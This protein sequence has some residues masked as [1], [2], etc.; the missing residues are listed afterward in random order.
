MGEISKGS[1]I[2]SIRGGD[3]ELGANG[4]SA[5]ASSDIVVED[6]TPLALMPLEDSL[7]L[8]L[9]TGSATITRSTIGTF[10]DKDDGLVKTA[11]IDTARFEA[12]SVLIEGASTNLLLRSEEFDNA[13][14]IKT[15]ASISANT[16]TA[17]DGNNTAD[18]IV[19]NTANAEHFSE[20]LFST[21]SG[22]PYTFSAYIKKSDHNTAVL[23]IPGIGFTGSAHVTLDFT[24]GVL[25]ESGTI[26]NSRVQALTGG[27]FRVSITRTAS[28]TVANA[29]ARIHTLQA[30][31]YT[32]DG[33]SGVF[34][35]RGQVEPL[36][37]ASSGIST[38]TI[39]VTKALED[40]DISSSNIPAPTDDYTVSVEVDVS[41]LDSTKTQTVYSVDGETDR[42]IVINTTTG[43]VE[44]THGAVTSVSTTALVPGTKVKLAFVVDGTNQT[45]YIN[46]VQEDQDAKGTVT[47]AAT[48][49]SIGNAA[50]LNELFGHIKSF[51]VYDVA[52]TA[53]QVAAL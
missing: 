22:N 43:L 50:G 7:E 5:V 1:G 11:A 36:P 26:D 8:V 35:W 24:I 47:G 28:S 31:S 32:G 23:R 52:L 44:A 30:S 51:R 29:L 39:S 20:Q 33:T 34:V 38:T 2:S 42:K 16:T 48:A 19:E 41:G 40:L 3:F 12:S 49:I 25:T 6:V 9:G 37:F 17:P 53:Q 10:V 21:L 13:A 45:L 27:W 4:I 46:G 15:Q 18:K 14:W